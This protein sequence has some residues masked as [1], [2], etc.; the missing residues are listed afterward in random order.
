MKQASQAM[1]TVLFVLTVGLSGVDAKEFLVGVELPLTGPLARVGKANFEGITVGVRMFNQ[2]HPRHTIKLIS[3]DDESSPAKAIAAVEKLASQ[4][5]LAITGGYGSHLV[6]PASSTA[7]KAGIAYLTS[8]G[9]ASE[10][11]TRG[12]KYFF[13]TNNTEGYAKGMVGLVSDLGV[14]SVS[15]VYSTKD[16]TSDLAGR[17]NKALGAKG[18]KVTMHSFDPAIT[19]FKPII[20]KIKIQDRSEL[21]AMFG[22]ENDYVGI[23]RA[24]KVLKPA[25][26]KAIVGGWSLATSKMAADFP[27]LMPN[28]YGGAMLSYPVDFRNAEG[29]AFAEEFR[30]LYKKDPEYMALYGYIQ[31]QILCEAIKRAD[32]KGILV[33]GGL[34]E[35][36]RKTNRDTLIGRLTF[37]ETGDTPNYL[38]KMGQHQNGK[39]VIVWPREHANGKKNFPAVP[40]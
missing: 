17:V 10:L 16:A 32:E 14:K 30:K 35:E 21:I 27:D 1:L 12:L 36:V 3:M 6:G 34:V 38:Q 7:E 25:T 4:G 29:K 23:I 33:R 15:M 9:A 39:I 19:D 31:A 11:T 37:D 8:G 5:V 2:K 20:N 18:I 24:A 13:R 26:V 28:V 40:W 22:Y